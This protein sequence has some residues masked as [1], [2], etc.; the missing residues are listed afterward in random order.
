MK[1]KAMKLDSV[2]SKW[3]VNKLTDSAFFYYNASHKAYLELNDSASA[4]NSLFSM[5]EIQFAAGDYPGSEASAAKALNIYESFKDTKFLLRVY[6]HLGA[7][8]KEL[9]NIDYAISYYKKASEIEKDAFEILKLQ[10]IMA[11]LYIAKSDYFTALELLNKALKSEAIDKDPAVKATVLDR[12]GYA[13]FK[14]G[15]SNSLKL[16]NEALKIRQGINNINGL[17]LSYIHLSEYYNSIDPENAKLYALKAYTIAWQSSNYKIKLRS[18]LRLIAVSDGKDADM[19]THHYAILKNDADLSAQAIESKFKKMLD[20]AALKA[21]DPEDIAKLEVSK[22]N[23]KIL[24]LA[25]V[26]S[27]FSSVLLFYQLTQRH[28]KE[29][30]LD[31]Y[32]AE[33]RLSKKIHDEIANEL[34]GTLHY[35]EHED[36]VSGS[37]K[38]KLI[39]QLDNIYLMTRNISR[40]NNDIDTGL[41]FPVQL[42]LML[43]TYSNDGVN[44]IVKGIS[45]INWEKIESIKKIAT[46]RVLQ[47]LMVNMDKHSKATVVLID[48]S[49]EKNKVKIIYSDN[50]IGTD[51]PKINLKNGLQNVENRMVSIGGSISFD[52]KSEKGFHLTLTYPLPILYV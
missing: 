50:G 24:T 39:E 9:S 44:V 25:L 2:A 10:S 8:H 32:A 51:C 49:T 41:R 6:K 18:L 34:Y 38:E 19:Y 28:K 31:A 46:Y 33:T 43:A 36:V 3:Q 52:S 26:A 30:L 42:K 11:R 47:E 22:D 5:S 13:S 27:I 1:S 20:A 23:N 40:E 7:T 35:I 29:R 37:K 17:T 21:N 12:I 14:Q 15:N 48:F 16:M 45:K 4:A